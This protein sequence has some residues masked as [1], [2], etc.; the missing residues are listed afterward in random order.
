MHAT[1]ELGDQVLLVAAIVGREHD[2]F[3]GLVAVVGDV[4]EVAILL[5]QPQLSLV[6]PQP[7][8]EHH[9]AIT[10][11]ASDRAIISSSRWIVLYPRSRTISGLTRAGAWRGAVLIAYRGRRSR[12]LY[13]VAERSSARAWRLGIAL[14]PKTKRMSPAPSQRSRC[15]LWV[16][17]VSPRSV[18][19]LNPARRQRLIILS[20]ASSAPSCEGRLPL[21]LT[22]YS[23]SDVLAS[24]IS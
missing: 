4:E 3:G 19:R 9:H 8:T 20:K 5:E 18:I 15:L 12:K 14:M 7:L 2:L 21:R 24:E 16:K 11:L 23:G 13:A 1:F 17:S 10:L 22:R 6:G